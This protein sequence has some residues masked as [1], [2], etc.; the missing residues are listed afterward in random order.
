[1][2]VIHLCVSSFLR[3]T[4]RPQPLCLTA[5][6]ELVLLDNLQVFLKNGFEF[7]IDEEG[8]RGCMELRHL[9]LTSTPY[10]SHTQPFHVSTSMVVYALICDRTY[11]FFIAFCFLRGRTFEVCQDMNVFLSCKKHYT[12]THYSPV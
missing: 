8:T 12:G 2:C 10:N 3:G 1:M 11:C 5:A 6:N 7:D 9:E 4:R